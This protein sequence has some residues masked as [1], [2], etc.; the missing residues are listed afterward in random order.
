MQLTPRQRP[1]GYLGVSHGECEDRRTCGEDLGQESIGKHWSWEYLESGKKREQEMRL[2]IL[3]GVSSWEWYKA[4][5]G[6]FWRGTLEELV[7]LQAAWSTLLILIV[8]LWGR[9]FS[10]SQE[11]ARSEF[12]AISVNPEPGPL[13]TVG[14]FVYHQSVMEHLLGFPCPLWHLYCYL[15]NA[16]FF[17]LLNL[18]LSNNVQEMICRIHWLVTLIC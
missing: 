6:L 11:V 2:E 17:F 13:T 9:N 8:A 12:E 1:K 18:F 3:R 5:P 16:F 7:R 10:Q 4:E 14:I 15:L